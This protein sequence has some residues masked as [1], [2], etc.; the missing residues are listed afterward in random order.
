MATTQKAIDFMKDFA[1][2]MKAR[3]SGL[4][5]TPGFSATDSSPT[6]LVGAASTGNEG[7]FLKLATYTSPNKDILGLTQNV[8][9]NHIAQIAFEANYASTSDNIADV[10]QWGS[11]LPAISIL[12]R[13]GL[14][15]EVYEETN[16]TAPSETTIAASKLKATFEGH[17]Q[18]PLIGSM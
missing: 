15:V 3:K 4:A 2:E 8:Y 11:H 14:R 6:L 9:A 12:A 7:F 16:G 17:L 1:A 13:M 18:Y 5:Q 10:Q